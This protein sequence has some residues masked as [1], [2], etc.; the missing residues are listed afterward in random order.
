MANKNLA[1]HILPAST[2]MVGVC[3][4]GIGLVKIIEART[5]PLHTDEYMALDALIFLTSGVFSYHALRQAGG[6]RQALYETL[7]DYTFLTG[8][9]AMA[10]ISVLFAFD[11]V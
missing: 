7:A 11:I 9:V 6:V 8:M 4:T 2:A 5:G 1:Q 3:L 10:A